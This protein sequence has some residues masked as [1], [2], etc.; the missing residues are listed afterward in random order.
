MKKYILMS[1]GF[2][3]P[4]PEVMTAWGK[5][6]DLIKDKTIDGG[7]HFAAAKKITKSGSEDLDYNTGSPTGYTI[8]EAENMA[9]VEELAQ[10]CPIIDSLVVLEVM[11]KG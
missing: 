11:A 3:K 9:A 6:F 2:E 4:T 8:I 7:G 1:Y 10:Q 5:W